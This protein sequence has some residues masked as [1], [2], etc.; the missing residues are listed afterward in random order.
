MTIFVETVAETASTNADVK[1]LALTGSAPEGFWLRAETQTGGVGRRGRK[2]ESPKG[3][4]FCSTV[5][6]MRPGDPEPSSL[7][8]VAGLAVHAAIRH[9]L[10]DVPMLLKWP[11]D[12]LVSD[13]KI[14]GILLERVKEQV[15]VGIGV[16]VAQA[17]QV[18]GRAVTS[19]KEEGAV[20]D[21]IDFLDQLSREFENWVKLWR[22]AG[23]AR[24]LREWEA[25]A[26]PVGMTVTTSDDG[27]DKISGEFA[28]LTV[29]GALRLRKAD[30]TLIAIRAGDIS[31]G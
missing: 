3:N 26:H 11:N 12:V 28:G 27:G 31:I 25:L 8:F 2:W 10:P 1:A 17:P 5:V 29:D 24:I 13:A 16:N 19:L 15:V 22:E 6:H 7:S 14:C 18:E 30:G 23:L 4:L 9:F 20:V 21:A